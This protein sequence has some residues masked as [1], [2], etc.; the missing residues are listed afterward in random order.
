MELL[1]VLAFA[2]ALCFSFLLSLLFA[3]GDAVDIVLWKRPIV[4]DLFLDVDLCHDN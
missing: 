3:V 2:F 4:V 1:L